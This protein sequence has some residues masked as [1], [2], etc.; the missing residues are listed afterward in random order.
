MNIKFNEPK[1]IRVAFLA[2]IGMADDDELTARLSLINLD[3]DRVMSELVKECLV[4]DFVQLS[5][6]MQ[7]RV[8]EQLSEYAEET[9]EL[10]DSFW[11]G[12][13]PPFSLP[14]D[15]REFLQTVRR[16]FEGSSS[17]RDEAPGQR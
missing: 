6:D 7:R 17:G 3:D 15:H 8:L 2:W 9:R 4:P 11:E 14:S 5:I 12:L 10:V 13:L 16:T 1:P